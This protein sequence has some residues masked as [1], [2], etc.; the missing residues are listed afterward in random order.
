MNKTFSD[1]PFCQHPFLW[2]L[3]WIRVRDSSGILSF[4]KAENLD[5]IFPLIK[6]V[7]FLDIK[8]K[9]DNLTELSKAY[10]IKFS[11]LET[12]TQKTEVEERKSETSEEE[13][14]TSSSD[15]SS[16]EKDKDNRQS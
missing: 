7:D 10:K 15:I 13:S 14:D 8:S 11:D 16:E 3:I 1:V 12:S 6:Y 9:E 2:P 4:T 5:C